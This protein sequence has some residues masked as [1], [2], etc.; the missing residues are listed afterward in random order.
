MQ[1]KAAALFNFEYG[2][3]CREQC[4]SR[5]GHK[6]AHIPLQLPKPC[7]TLSI[8]SRVSRMPLAPTVFE[9]IARINAATTIA[10]TWTVY[11]G[12]ARDLGLKFGFA[13]FLP[14]DKNLAESIFA[15]DFPDNWLNNYVHKDYRLHD[16]LM[17]LSH[18]STSAFSWSMA[19]WEGLLTGKQKDWRNDNV[20]AGLCGGL[21]I[22]DRRDG[23]LKI[24]SLSG[25]PGTLDRDDQ[26]ALYYAGLETLARM[27][28]LGLHGDDCPFPPLSPR[29]REC[30]HWLAAGKSDWEAGQI[31]SI[32]EKTVATHIDRMKHKLGVATRAQAI[33]VAL[34]HRVLNT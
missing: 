15:N 33:V 10:D 9:L 14:D 23:H 34:R 7:G 18:E 6:R 5:S 22:P 28:E 4:A 16:P 21:I 32:S 1:L 2:F 17:R 27:H 26:K 19:D 20:S 12:A 13:A 29:E 24:I 8:A 30:L 31:L 3:Y 25:T 11:M